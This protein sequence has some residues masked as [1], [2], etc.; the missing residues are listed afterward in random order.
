MS[1]HSVHNVEMFTLTLF[2]LNSSK[3]GSTKPE[4][5]EVPEAV[6]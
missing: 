5:P 6:F 4:V 3:T 2:V 1:Q